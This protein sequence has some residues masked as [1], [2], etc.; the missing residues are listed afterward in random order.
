M[1]QVQLPSEV[2]SPPKLNPKWIKAFARQWRDFLRDT[3]F[4]EPARNG[5]RGSAFAY[6][7]SLIM[8]I[9]VLAVKCKVKTYLGIHRLAVTYWSQ[10]TPDAALPPISESQ[11]R[12]RLKNRPHAWKACRIHFSSA[13]SRRPGI[14]M[15]WTPLLPSVLTR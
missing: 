13:S 1:S 8:L 14:T 9:A 7:E 4:P 5:A 10:I 12:E 15:M 3:G 6:P 2:E 11:L